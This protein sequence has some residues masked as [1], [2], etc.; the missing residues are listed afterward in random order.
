MVCSMTGFGRSE[1][2]EGERKYI[3]ELKSVNN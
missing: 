2:T 3:V 1:I